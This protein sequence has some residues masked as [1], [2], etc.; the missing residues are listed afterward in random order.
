MSD[1]LLLVDD[2]PHALEGYR[3][4]LGRQF[5]IDCACSGEE[6]LAAIAAQGPYAVIISD[7]KM[8]DMNGVEFLTKARDLAPHAIRMMLTGCDIACAID[9][10]NQGS[11]FRFLTKPCE[12]AV[13]IEAIEDGLRLHQTQAAERA[14]LSTTLTGAIKILVDILATL[15]PLAFGR[16]MRV[17]GL[18]RR[19]AEKLTPDQIWRAEIAAML[20]QIG[21]VSISDACLQKAYA[22]ERLPGDDVRLFHAH[23]RTGHDLVANVPRLGEVADIIL[24]QER[25]FD[26][27]GF[28][29][30][31]L[32]GEKLPLE[33]RMLK[34]A[35]D[36]DSLVLKGSCPADALKSLYFRSGRYDPK[37]LDAL[38]RSL[39]S[40]AA[41]DVLALT[42]DG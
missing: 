21:C 20:C 38:T 33:S 25:S 36:F 41:R 27:G 6:G 35:L 17:R 31:G 39:A 42:A 23:P 1:K 29:D 19:M 3:R 40:D 32:A 18:V 14:L 37:V 22:N 28:P 2:E 4:Q 34:V 30:T 9:A 11:V 16:A 12:A 26:G 13:L 15:K 24:N 10:V 7:M 5:T 8:N